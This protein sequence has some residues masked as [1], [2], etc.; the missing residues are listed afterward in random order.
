[1]NTIDD[2]AAPRRRRWP[3]VIGL[4]GAVSAAVW[5]AAWFSARP[6]VFDAV[7][8][9]IADLDRRGVVVACGDRRIEGFPFRMV[10]ACRSPGVASTRDGRRISAE[11][12]RVGVAIVDPFRPVAEFDG[13]ITAEDGRGGRLVATVRSARLTLGWSTNGVQRIS[14]SLDGPD[15]TTSGADRPTV[16]LVASRIELDGRRGEGRDLD[17]AAS[18]TATT[19]TV[20]GRRVGPVRSDLAVSATLREASPGPDDVDPIA[21]FVARGGRIDPLRL[22]L[23]VAGLSLDGVGALRLDADGR[24][25]GRLPVI[26]HGLSGTPTATADL[27]PELTTVLGGFALLGRPV[28]DDDGRPGRRLDLTVEAGDVRIGRVGLGRIPP[29]VAVA[30]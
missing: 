16:R 21:G 15:A 8:R 12:L 6:F 7:D 30:R 13:P 24:L 11:A 4:L 17:L 5:T 3:L 2:G 14:L 9:G 10:F 29:L 23:A 20:A 27:G 18:S 22:S 26:A 19:L 1:M 28:V 25:S